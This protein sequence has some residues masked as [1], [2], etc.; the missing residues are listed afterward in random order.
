MTG[1]VPELARLRPSRSH[2][3]LRLEA[4]GRTHALSHREALELVFGP[5]PSAGGAGALLD[6]AR[7]GSGRALPCPLYVWGFDSV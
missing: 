1:G 2:G 5:H 4:E 3:G 6:A 7:T